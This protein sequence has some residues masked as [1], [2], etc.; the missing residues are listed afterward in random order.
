METAGWLGN[1]IEELE[2]EDEVEAAV[3]G[4]CSWACVFACACELMG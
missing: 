3:E 2:R 4:E 1:V